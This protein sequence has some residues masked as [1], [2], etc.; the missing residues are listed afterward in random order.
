MKR[1]V[2]VLVLL[3]LPAV[4]VAEIY[5]WVDDKGEIGFA[6]DLGKVPA[7]Y[8]KKATLLNGQESAVE[9]IDK[10]EAEKSPR[11][12]GDARSDQSATGDEKPKSKAKEKSLYDGK[13][14]ETWR[15]DFSRLKYD[16]KAL[17]EQSAANKERMANPGKMSRGEYLSLQN[18]QRDLE[19]RISLAQKKLDALNDAADRAD[20]P[21]EFR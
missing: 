7:K 18:T 12:G 6:E 15:R 21:G 3:A 1:M 17:E 2:L 5:Q 14:G 8:R 4:C 9:I 16:V 19:Y 10:T 13:D 20:V 11:K